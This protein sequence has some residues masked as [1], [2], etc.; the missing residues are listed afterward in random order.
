MVA[1]LNGQHV[2]TY[3]GKLLTLMKTGKD[4]FQFF[5][6]NITL[7]AEHHVERLMFRAGDGHKQKWTRAVRAILLL[8]HVGTPE[9]RALL[10][11]MASGH[12]DACPTRSAKDALAR[13]AK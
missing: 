3:K 9:A 10:K 7:W 5:D 12:V 1:V 8:E 2:D 4:S 13:L 6:G 11:S